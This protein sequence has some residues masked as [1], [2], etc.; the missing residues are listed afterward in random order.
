M[1]FL[2]SN[3][4]I[5]LIVIVQIILIY[6]GGELFRTVGLSLKEFE[7]MLLLS[8]TVVPVDWIRKIILRSKGLKGGF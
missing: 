8:M 5:S 3:F 1:D 6:Y 2:R 7:I 4:I